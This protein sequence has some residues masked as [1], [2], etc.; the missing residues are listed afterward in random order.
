MNHTNPDLLAKIIKKLKILTFYKIEKTKVLSETIAKYLQILPELKNY[1]NENIPENESKIFFEL[2]KYLQYHKYKKGKFIKHSY[3]LDNFFYMVLSGKVAKID[4]KYCRMYLSFKEYL[5]HLIKLKLLEE[6]YIYRKCI[7][8]NKKVFPF[9]E[10]INVLTTKEINIEHYQELIKNIKDEI[11][12]SFWIKNKNNINIQDFLSLY[13]PEIINSKFDFNGKEAKYPAYLPVYI[14][15]KILTPISF[16]GQLTKPKEIRFLSSY[17]CLNNSDIFYIEKSEIDKNNNLYNLFQRRVSEDVVQKLFKNHF[18]F[19]EVDNSF[20]IKNYSKYFYVLK[21][22]KGQKLIQQNTPYEGIYF[23][24]EGIF[25]LKTIRSYNELNDLRFSVM[26]SLDNFP[27]IYSS[28]Q[29]KINN[30]EKKNKNNEKN[31]YQGLDQDQIAKFNEKKEISFKAY[32]SNDVVGL[33]DIYDNITGLNNFTVECLS[34]EAEVYYLPK[35]IVTS[36]LANDE[37]NSKVGEF[38]GEQCLLHISEINKYKASFEETIQ[39]ESNNYKENKHLFKIRNSFIFKKYKNKKYHS[40]HF[41]AKKNLSIGFANFKTNNTNSSTNKSNNSINYFN[42][43]NKTQISNNSNMKIIAK[44]K[45]KKYPY[46]NLNNINYKNK[47]EKKE[48]LLDAP[49][50][51]KNR[52]NYYKTFSHFY[53]PRTNKSTDIKVQVCGLYLTDKKKTEPQGINEENK[54]R[55]NNIKEQFNDTLNEFHK[56]K[57]LF[58]KTYSKGILKNGS[59]RYDD[60]IHLKLNNNENKFKSSEKKIKFCSIDKKF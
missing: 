12:N 27:K 52:N 35:E 50:G 48:S 58:N 19:K 32:L 56:R 46:L 17:I 16:I 11:N 31:I 30:I 59:K 4:I 28:Y 7:K 40:L 23:I 20:L 44:K 51:I 54:N 34:D 18:F 5:K 33:N 57:L 42:T 39:F 37:I 43:F 14:F 45:N 22:E 3:D 21:L 53:T 2:G 60:Q 38:I 47:E 8:K 15:D 10:N 29:K 24:K 6:N 36:M 55:I 41:R 49:N 13:N 1:V 26:H 25:Q 9:D